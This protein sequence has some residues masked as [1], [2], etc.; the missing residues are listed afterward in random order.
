MYRPTRRHIVAA[1]ILCTLLGIFGIWV[2]L[3]P[4]SVFVQPW[5]AAKSAVEENVMFGPYPVEED[6]VALK[7]RGVTTIISLLDSNIPYEKVLLAQER[8]RAA[9]YGMEVQNFP[10]ASILGQKF[11]RDYVRNSEAAARAALAANGTA[12]IHC[13]LGLHRAGNVQKYLDTF[14]ASSTYVGIRSERPDDVLAE[15]RALVA[16][17]AG[18]YQGSLAELGKI[19][20]KGIRASRQQAWTYYRMQRIDEARA[21]FEQVL[22]ADPED[23]DSHVGLA[24]C[25]LA[26]NK[27]S[28][29]GERFSGVLVA[30]PGDIGA[31]EGLGHVRF[32]QSDLL[33]AQALFARAAQANPEN[34]ETQQMMERLQRRLQQS[35]PAQAPTGAY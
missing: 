28:E 35:P 5:R 24:Y 9:R 31:I 3:H 14:A 7:A 10:M 25:A 12:Y 21:G 17:R 18:D 2:L 4:A 30:N 29:A 1:L 11:G 15:E 33:E 8:E 20:E 27:L 13:Y 34:Q 6:F 23:Q 26:E 16:F 32:R 19:P 22:R